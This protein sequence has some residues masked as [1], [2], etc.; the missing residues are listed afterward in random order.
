M[1]AI[2]FEVKAVK[3]IT[4]DQVKAFKQNVERVITMADSVSKLTV[5]TDADDKF[6]AVVKDLYAK[7][8][9]VLDEPWL[10]DFL[11]F[12]LGFLQTQSPEVA[13]KL[14]SLFEAK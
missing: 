13:E 6:V 3:A 12:L 8:S 4:P 14:A 9:P 10:P 5:F 1:S 11:S 7:V 2:D